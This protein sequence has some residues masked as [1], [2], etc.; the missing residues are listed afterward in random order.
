MKRILKGLIGASLIGAILWFILLFFSLFSI[1]NL[2]SRPSNNQLRILS[3]NVSAGNVLNNQLQNNIILS[4]PDIITIVEW[5][6]DNIDL[7]KFNAAGYNI[8]INHPRKRVHGICIL[9]KQ[10]GQGEIIESPIKTPCALPLGQFRFKWQDRLITLF[11]VHAPPP[12]P[13]CEGTT[14]DYLIAISNWITDSRLNQNIG[15]GKA[16]DLTILAGDFNTVF[17]GGGI[18]LLKSKGLKDAHS[19]F[20]GQTWKPFNGFPYIAKIDYIL[21]PNLFSSM[22]SIRFNIDNS[23]HLGIQTDLEIRGEKQ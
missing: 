4:N 8:I 23:D 1:D 17:L 2:S 22:N 18:R 7:K 19:S 12:V 20:V 13:S 16:G 5:T 6:G 15:L 9:S 10:K 21:A 3:M 11:A 14:S